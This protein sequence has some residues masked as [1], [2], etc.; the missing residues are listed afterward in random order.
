MEQFEYSIAEQEWWKPFQ[1]E[2]DFDFSEF[3]T[4]HRLTKSV[5]DDLLQ[6]LTV[7]CNTSRI[8]FKTHRDVDESTTAATAS[9]TKVSAKSYLQKS[10]ILST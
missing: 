4:K 5:I 8:S 10:N 7:W 6:R 2:A 3:I 1:S 9:T